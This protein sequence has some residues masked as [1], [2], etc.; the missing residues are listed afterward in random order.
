MR[1]RQDFVLYC[2]ALVGLGTT[3]IFLLGQ[4]DGFLLRLYESRRAILLGSS[5]CYLIGGMVPCKTIFIVTMGYIHSSK[6][7]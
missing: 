5:I 7:T 3:F 6:A 2:A 1:V 4:P